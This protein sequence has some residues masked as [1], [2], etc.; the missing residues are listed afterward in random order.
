MV[1]RFQ[2]STIIRGNSHPRKIVD[3]HF[4]LGE[5]YLDTRNGTLYRA[6]T[7][8]IKPE[9]EKL[10]SGPAEESGSD[11]ASAYEVAVANGFNGSV[12][13]W[14]NSLEGAP[15]LDGSGVLILEA[16]DVVPE[17]TPARTLIVR[18]AP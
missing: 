13:E 6:K 15:G 14:L 11:G 16:N 10:F 3:V 8:G 1:T 4:E 12:Q 5:L 9:W 18:K 2:E 7:A 17:G